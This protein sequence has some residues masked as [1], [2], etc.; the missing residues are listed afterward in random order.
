LFRPEYDNVHLVAQTLWAAV[1]GVISLHIAKC[2]D[3]WV[4]WQPLQDRVEATLDV[5]LRGLL[6]EAK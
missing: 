3:A 5:T 2:N 4:E 6:K 1:H